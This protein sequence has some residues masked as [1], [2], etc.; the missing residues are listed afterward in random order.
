MSLT[1]T[2]N[3]LK[4][5][6]LLE[7]KKHLPIRPQWFSHE[8]QEGGELSY[9]ASGFSKVV[10]NWL[11]DIY[12]GQQNV[13]LTTATGSAL[14]DWGKDFGVSR[15]TGEA[16]DAYR[17]RIK[18]TIGLV[19]ITEDG[20]K[21]FVSSGT[22]LETWITTPWKQQWFISVHPDH[23]SGTGFEQWQAQHGW[24][25]GQKWS[26]GYYT[27]YVIDVHTR[28]FSPFTLG[29]VKRGKAA[30]IRAYLTNWFDLPVLNA[31]T[32]TQRLQRSV[33][34][35]HLLPLTDRL[36][37]SGSGVW[38]G[39]SQHFADKIEFLE[40]A[41]RPAFNRLALDTASVWAAYAG[42]SWQQALD[43]AIDPQPLVSI[44]QSA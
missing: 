43:S 16:D 38:G 28:G 11:G 30:G 25:G 4:S 5:L 39:K 27:G 8:A 37:L 21:A 12:T 18:A 40:P 24:S 19:T 41:V 36:I 22:G 33:Y 3:L 15:L 7:F 10:A 1:D 34:L 9:L 29:L 13:F 31:P 2:K 17:A 44:K 26:D 35:D 32:L 14:D 20:L 6:T 23:Y 42:V